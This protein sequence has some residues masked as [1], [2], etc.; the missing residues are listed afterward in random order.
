MCCEPDSNLSARVPAQCV[1][2]RCTEALDVT[3]EETVQAFLHIMDLAKQRGIRIHLWASTP[4]TAGCPWKY[5]N[6]SK[7]LQTGNPDATVKII[8]NVG[9]LC[10]KAV[11]LGGDFSWE[12]SERSELW[13]WEDTKELF[14]HIETF[15][16]KVPLHAAG[17]TFYKRVNGEMTEVFLSKT[18]EDSH[19]FQTLV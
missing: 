6:A 12:W 4:C 8:R 11:A 16:V 3:A 14:D 15:E 19:N 5:V 2:I 17:C 1:S 7:G 18:V 10:Q 13:K 9:I